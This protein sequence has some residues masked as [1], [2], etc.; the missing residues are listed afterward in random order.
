[1]KNKRTILY[2][3]DEEINLMLF[4]INFKE[5]YHVIG[6][7]SPLKGL[8]ILK[9]NHE[10]SVVI[11]DMRM[12]EMNGIQFIKKAKKKFPKIC[13]FILT[14]YDI[15]DEIAEALNNKLINFYFK[16]PFNMKEIDTSIQKVFS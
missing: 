5:K 10:I 3:D 11:S 12:P 9:D 6:T 16:K 13:Y 14:G 15:T 4:E 7:D 8:Q 1:M 2:V